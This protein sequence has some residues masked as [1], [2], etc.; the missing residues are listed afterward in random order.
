MIWILPQRK[1]GAV[2]VTLSRRGEEPFTDRS[3]EGM[4]FVKGRVERL[5]RTIFKAEKENF[6]DSDRILSRGPCTV[7][8]NNKLRAFEVEEDF[9]RLLS[10]CYEGCVFVKSS[11]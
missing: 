9:L 6:S 4:A 11:D 10:F 3:T 8:T 2:L 7:V 1:Q 5:P